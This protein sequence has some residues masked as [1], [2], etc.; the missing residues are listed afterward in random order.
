L[1]NIT[2][3]IEEDEE[4]SE[5]EEDSDEDESE[6]GTGSKKGSNKGSYS[7]KS[8]ISSKSSGK[9]ASGKVSKKSKKVKADAAAPAPAETSQSSAE[10]PSVAKSDAEKSSKSVSFSVDVTPDKDKGASKVPPPSAT[11]PAP[12][13]PGGPPA[14]AVPPPPPPKATRTQMNFSMNTA[15]SPDAG[16]SQH[17]SAT[18]TSVKS[19]VNREA[20]LTGGKGLNVSF[21]VDKLAIEEFAEAWGANVSKPQ[22]KNTS[23]HGATSQ[24]SHSMDANDAAGGK[25]SIVTP[26]HKPPTSTT[27]PKNLSQHIVLPPSADGNPLTTDSVAALNAENA[28][29]T[30]AGNEVGADAPTARPTSAAYNNT[31]AGM[32]SK[33]QL[34][35]YVVREKVRDLKL[36]PVVFTETLQTG[37]KFRA[38]VNELAAVESASIQLMRLLLVPKHTLNEV[39]Q[40][41]AD[42]KN[43]RYLKYLQIH[44][45]AHHRKTLIGFG[46]SPR[47]ASVKQSSKNMLMSKSTKAM[48]MGTSS[49]KGL[50]DEVDDDNNEESYEDMAHPAFELIHQK[51]LKAEAH[52][53]DSKDGSSKAGVVS[54][55]ENADKPD[56]HG[57]GHGHKGELLSDL[58]DAAASEAEAADRLESHQID[59]SNLFKVANHEYL[60]KVRLNPVDL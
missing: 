60:K 14:V 31:E 3:I 38:S 58:L 48:V 44:T 2:A 7:G 40:Y 39:R 43:M 13:N 27:T 25:L 51:R 54:R 49:R 24:R 1:A 42:P 28:G 26:D 18:A 30:D 22:G 23:T 41:C 33:Q 15:K 9:A 59:V 17:S 11:T 21:A 35:A 55:N 8:T 10:P 53:K 20:A 52:K 50:L 29:A 5:E 57:H 37:A 6:P 4:E 47:D 32:T 16:T 46:R 36:P 19:S 34:Q 45:R 56:G 12:Q